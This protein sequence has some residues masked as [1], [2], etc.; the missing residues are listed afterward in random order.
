[1]DT[2]LTSQQMTCAETLTR[3][4]VEFTCLS[5]P[6]HLTL[7]LVPEIQHSAFV[8][9]VN[10]AKGKFSIPWPAMDIVQ[11]T[12]PLLPSLR[13]H[14]QDLLILTPFHRF[15]TVMTA[16]SQ[17]PQNPGID[18]DAFDKTLSWPFTIS[19]TE[20]HCA[21]EDMWSSNRPVFFVLGDPSLHNS[22]IDDMWSASK[23]SVFFV[24]ADLLFTTHFLSPFTYRI[25]LFGLASLTSILSPRCPFAYIS[26]IFISTHLAL[27]C[28]CFH[29]SFLGLHTSRTLQAH[30]EARF[31]SIKHQTQFLAGHIDLHLVYLVGR[32]VH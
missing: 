28:N 7:S 23:R 2:P 20:G 8:L 14:P 12:R 11:L 25:S 29:L 32:Q 4:G 9:L 19:S 3:T 30:H 6:L 21:I 1:M 18:T 17:K 27:C 31:C 5:L 10:M 26:S 15:S 16:S 24:L 13:R 22:L